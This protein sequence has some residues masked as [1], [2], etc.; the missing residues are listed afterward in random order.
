MALDLGVSHDS[1]DLAFLRQC[2]LDDGLRAVLR[3]AKAIEAFGVFSNGGISALA[4]I[5]ENP[6]HQRAGLLLAAADVAVRHASQLLLGLIRV[7]QNT[8]GEGCRTAL[9]QG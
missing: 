3:Q 4:N 2:S 1:L 6:V 8:Q 7:L 9:R 5:L